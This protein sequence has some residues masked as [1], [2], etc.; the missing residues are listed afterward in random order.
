M[1]A[2]IKSQVVAHTRAVSDVAWSP[3]DPC[4]VAT[5]SADTYIHMWD[6][7]TPEQKV[8]SFCTWNGGG[9]VVPL[10]CTPSIHPHPSIHPS[11]CYLSI[12]PSIHPSIYLLSTY[13]SIHSSIHLF[14]IYLLST[15]LSIPSPLNVCQCTRPI[16]FDC[17]LFFFLQRESRRSDGIVITVTFLLLRTMDKFAYGTRG[18]VGRSEQTD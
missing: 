7:R 2:P 5:C 16:D 4:V 18:Y 12:H 9:S 3:H 15:Y 10:R 1:K 6:I 17:V 11:I 13:L 8:N 14:I